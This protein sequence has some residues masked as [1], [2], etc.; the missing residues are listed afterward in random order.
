[1]STRQNKELVRQFLKE[2][3]EF[4]GDAAKV[5]SWCEKYYAPSSVFHNLV[6]GDLNREQMVQYFVEIMS[7]MP[8]FYKSIDDMVAEGDKVVVRY[9]IQGTPKGTFG[10]L[11]TNGKR[12]L[13]TASE[14]YKIGAG[15]ILEWWEFPDYLGLYTQA[16]AILSA[17]P[18]T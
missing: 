2:R 6:R 18:K 5:R 4:A 16:G 17:A 12:I 15:K 1:M 3:N 14:I 10:G 11:I 8:D 9:K 7:V 13:I